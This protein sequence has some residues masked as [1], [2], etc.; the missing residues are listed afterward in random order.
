MKHIKDKLWIVFPV[1]LALSIILLVI[2]SINLIVFIP[3]IFIVV[4]AFGWGTFLA[5]KNNDWSDFP[6]WYVRLVTETKFGYILIFL[7]VIVV[8]LSLIFL[9]GAYEPEL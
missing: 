6:L 8:L 4:L 9:G 7:S 5:E 3:L 1:G 2:K